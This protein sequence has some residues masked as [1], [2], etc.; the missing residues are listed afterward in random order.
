[1]FGISLEILSGVQQFHLYRYI[2]KKQKQP[3]HFG[4]WNVFLR[5]ELFGILVGSIMRVPAALVLPPNT[6]E[7]ASVP[8]L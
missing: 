1:M 5:V 2:Q 8:V 4:Y 3:T 7:K 6:L